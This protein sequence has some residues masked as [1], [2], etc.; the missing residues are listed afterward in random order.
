LTSD[1]V[2]VTDDHAVESIKRVR[3][4][5]GVSLADVAERSDLHREAVARAE[6]PGID[7]RASTVAA[8]ADALRVPVCQL[9]ERTGHERPR[10]HRKAR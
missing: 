1:N 5:L 6:R 9:F 4:A 2:C 10:T 3:K 8:I 7:P